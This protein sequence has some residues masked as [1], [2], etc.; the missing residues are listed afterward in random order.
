M[1]VG[2]ATGEPLTLTGTLVEQRG[3]L[4]GVQVFLGATFAST[5]GPE[6]A[7]HLRFAAIGGI[8][9]NAALAR[10]G[11]LD[12]LPCH[13]ST[14]PELISSGRLS[15]D[16]VLVQLS[17]LGP[18]GLHSLGLVG[19]YLSPAIDRARVVIAEIN[20]QVPYTLGA[21]AVHPD[22]LDA[23]VHT[24]RTP[25]FVE[26]PRVGPAEAAIGELIATLVPD[27]AVIQL[28]VGA[29]PYAV[30][31]GLSA[32]RDLGVHSGVVGDWIVDL[33][34]SGVVTNMSKA[35][36]RGITV[37]GALFGTRRLYDYAH[38]NPS[39]QLR[40]IS[41][42]HDVAVLRQLDRLMAINSAVEVDLTGQVNAETVG[43]VHIG[44]VGGQVD[45]V[46]AAMASRGGRSIIALPSTAR[47]GQVSRIVGH[48][49]DGVITTA[50]SDA[51]LVVTEHGVADL[52]GMT[53]R[54]RAEQLIAIADPR[55]K[56]ELQAGLEGRARL[57]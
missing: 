20:E 8:G 17:P 32:K 16:V 50:R 1:L 2:Q 12:V 3:S 14:L 26:P 30:A 33:M 19:D 5:F 47:G 48:L 15:V 10:A 29:V 23:V 56:A 28:G 22:Q 36:D 21:G 27:G 40:P 57:C 42:T 6:Q 13:V 24:S 52:R 11:V 37:T 25:V 31:K 35:V 54:Q 38:R 53:L 55:F 39:L 7:D 51:D 4:G 46:R 43:G 45:F 49:A 41:Y 44:T 18:E 9:T 34:E